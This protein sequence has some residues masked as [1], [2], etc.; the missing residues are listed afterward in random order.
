MFLLQLK[1]I[2]ISK[3][4]SQEKLADLIGM[5]QSNYSRR[6]NGK[7]EISTSEWKRIA[8]AL[9]VNLEEIYE[10]SDN[11]KKIDN[12]IDHSNILKHYLNY[13]ESLENEIANLKEKL[14]AFEE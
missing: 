4:I 11:S 9:D 6:E 10:Y 5:T 7:K 3:G 13:T 8:K 14:K 12:S 1:K 2:R